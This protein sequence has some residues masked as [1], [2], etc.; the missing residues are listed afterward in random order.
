MFF[1]FIIC[2]DKNGYG[3]FI[4]SLLKIKIDKYLKNKKIIV[5]TCL[6]N[7]NYDILRKFLG[8]YKCI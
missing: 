2:S 7:E 8:K 4:E 3:N 6:K 1:R 5:L